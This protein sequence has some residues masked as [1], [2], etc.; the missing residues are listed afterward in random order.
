MDDVDFNFDMLDENFVSYDD[1]MADEENKIYNEFKNIQ[2]GSLDDEFDQELD[3]E[4]YE[5]MDSNAQQEGGYMVSMGSGE[6]ENPYEEYERPQGDGYL[7][8]GLSGPTRGG[9]PIAAVISAIPAIIQAAP[10]LIS[11]VKSGIEWIT[12]KN[13]KKERLQEASASG[14]RQHKKIDHNMVVEHLSKLEKHIPE[15][16]KIEKKSLR[17]KNINPLTYYKNLVQATG[18]VLHN[19]LEFPHEKVK[20]YI[21]STMKKHFGNEMKDKIFKSDEDDKAL[22]KVKKLKY[23]D[24]IQPMTM[25]RGI[26]TLKKNGMNEDDSKKMSV[27]LNETIMT[28]CKK[29]LNKPISDLTKGGNVFKTLRNK[30]HNSTVENGG[31]IIRRL[32]KEYPYQIMKRSIVG[33]KRHNMMGKVLKAAQ[34]ASNLA[35]LGNHIYNYMSKSMSPPIQTQEEKPPSY[36]ESEKTMPYEEKE[37]TAPPVESKGGSKK[38]RKVVKTQKLFNEM[39]RNIYQA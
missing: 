37:P 19:K 38:K 5:F 20:D 11:L 3:N 39:D 31:K 17:H 18:Y 36:E 23:S 28:C 7:T 34:M 30:M 15:L 8:S 29:Q 1:K 16:K 9:F 14:M 12:G 22:P 32:P 26:H 35:P 27:L 2:G 13:K 6:N 4:L 10:T 25:G 21:S 33:K 24:L